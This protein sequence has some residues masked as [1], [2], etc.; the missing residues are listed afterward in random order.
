MLKQ[1]LKNKKVIFIIGDRKEEAAYFARQILKEKFSV[2]YKERLPG[3]LDVFSIATKDIIL[4]KESKEDS[5]RKIK[6]FLEDL[7]DCTIVITET[8]RKAKV[9][10]ILQGSLEDLTLILDFSI[11]KKIKKKKKK[12]VLTFGINKKRAHF[13]ITDIYQKERE[14][15]F[16]INYEGNTIPFWIQEKLKSK[17]IYGV[18]PA[19]S[20]AK[21]FKLNLADVSYKIKEELLS[22]TQK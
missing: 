15:N 20:L 6:K 1:L 2:F 8:K 17:E 3:T 22:F 10:K 4:L 11:A 21:L 19:L 5:H 9:R 7:P 16:K 14:T 12:K 18:L 13:C